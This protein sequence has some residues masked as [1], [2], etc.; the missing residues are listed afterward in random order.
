MGVFQKKNPKTTEVIPRVS[1]H[2]QQTNKLLYKCI[3]ILLYTDSDRSVAPN[4][5]WLLTD[6]LGLLCYSFTWSLL[7]PS[8]NF[9]DKGELRFETVKGMTVSS[10][11]NLSWIWSSIISSHPRRKST[12]FSMSETSGVIKSWFSLSWTNHIKLYLTVND[13]TIK[14]MR[15]EEGLWSRH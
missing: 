6:P 1:G 7:L 13:A 14:C 8:R 12:L 15:F 3:T 10:K 11:E 4:N 5:F 2:W 9:S